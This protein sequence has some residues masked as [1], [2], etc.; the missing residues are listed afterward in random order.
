MPV[1]DEYAA[2]TTCR[3]HTLVNTQPLRGSLRGQFYSQC[4][5]ARF[6]YRCKFSHTIFN[7]N[8][9][10]KIGNRD[11][12]KS[13][14]VSLDYGH[15]FERYGCYEGWDSGW[16]VRVPDGS[17]YPPGPSKYVGHARVHDL[18]KALLLEEA[19]TGLRAAGDALTQYGKVQS[20]CRAHHE[21]NA[22]QRPDCKFD[23]DLVDSAR[24]EKLARWVPRDTD[25][26]DVLTVECRVVEG[27]TT[28]KIILKEAAFAKL[29]ATDP[30][31]HHITS[32]PYSYEAAELLDVV[33]HME[34]VVGLATTS[35]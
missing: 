7:I 28:W 3:D 30:I 8:R 25:N 33:R 29:K 14:I 11:G 26:Y 34:Q 17:G 16:D 19:H 22:C 24:I 5:K 23:H 27:Q 9:V 2:R 13:Y 1:N 35:T 10:H 4:E 15:G 20:L 18:P 21:L 6:D 31:A 12:R 32:R